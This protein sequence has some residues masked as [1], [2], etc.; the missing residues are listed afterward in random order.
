MSRFIEAG[1]EFF[2]RIFFGGCFWGLIKVRVGGNDFPG[3]RCDENHGV[4]L[5]KGLGRE[6]LSDCRIVVKMLEQEIGANVE[7]FRTPQT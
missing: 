1:F 3:E 7:E 5:G 4:F 2:P 6:V